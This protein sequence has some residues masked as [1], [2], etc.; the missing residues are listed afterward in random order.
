MHGNVSVIGLSTPK[1]VLRGKS[2]KRTMKICKRI[3]MDAID[4]FNEEAGDLMEE[5]YHHNTKC[6]P[7]GCTEG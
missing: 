3:F 2:V 7:L 4:L 6:Y 5:V 1:V